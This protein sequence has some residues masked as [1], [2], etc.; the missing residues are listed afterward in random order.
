MESRFSVEAKAFYFLAVSGKQVLRLGERRKG[1]RGFILLGVK[2]SVW[3]ADMLEDAFETQRREDFARSFCDEVRVLKV[4][5]G[6]NMVGCFLEVV[7]RGN[8]AP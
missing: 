2:A 3:L 7:E 8:Q 5:M 1:F 4:R 6:R